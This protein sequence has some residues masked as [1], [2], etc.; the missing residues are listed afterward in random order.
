ML[1]LLDPDASAIKLDP[2]GAEARA[3]ALVEDHLQP[4]AMDAD[5][6]KFVTGGF[7]A[8]L[9]IN[10]L[11]EAIVEA[12]FAVLDASCKQFFLQAERGEFAHAMRQ[13]RDA[14]AE[15]FHLRRAL[16]DAAGHAAFMQV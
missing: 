4:A 15:L 8:R 16:E 5:F 1:V 12:A 9:A 14:D 3:G 11:T 10:Q 7:A 13:E 2:L 6:W